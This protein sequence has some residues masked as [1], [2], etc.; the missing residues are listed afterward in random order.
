MVDLNRIG[1]YTRGYLSGVNAFP[2]ICPY[3]PESKTN[4]DNWT[5][6]FDDG[7]KDRQD[8]LDSME[9]DDDE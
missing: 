9:K 7:V 8:L 5:R 4:C 6:G 2:R 1:A 3:P